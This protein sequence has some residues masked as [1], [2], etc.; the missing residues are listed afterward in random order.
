MLA[1]GGTGSVEHLGENMGASRV[2]L[3][4]DDMAELEAQ[5]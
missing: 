2:D 5:G 1:I 4:A 3:T